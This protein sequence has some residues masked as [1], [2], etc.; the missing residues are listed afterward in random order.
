MK[1]SCLLLGAIS[2]SSA[3]DEEQEH[4][5]ACDCDCGHENLDRNAQFAGVLFDQPPD[6]PVHGLM[7]MFQFPGGEVHLKSFIT[8]LSPGEHLIHVHEDADFTDGCESAGEHYYPE[9][10]GQN[11]EA[12]DDGKSF[13]II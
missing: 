10:Q 9:D 5:N 11:I 4:T 2:L 12:D 3:Q 8:G 7:E 13:E 6:G 1:F